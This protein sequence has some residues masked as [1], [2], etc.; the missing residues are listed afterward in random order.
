MLLSF[1][2]SQVQF[3]HSNKFKVKI[4]LFRF[5]P[6]QVQFTLLFALMTLTNSKVSIPHRFNSHAAKAP[7]FGF[8][9]L[10]GS[11]HTYN[12]VL[13]G[14]IAKYVSIPH[15]FNSHDAGIEFQH[16]AVEFQSLTGSIHTAAGFFTWCRLHSFNPS[17]VQFTLYLYLYLS[18]IEE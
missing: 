2:P 11:I 6:S 16:Q 1:N 14:L 12:I 3:T 18:L 9:S 10:T 13:V 17:Q 5:N 8:Q 15:R 7:P 4:S